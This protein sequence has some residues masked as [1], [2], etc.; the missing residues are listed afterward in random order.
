VLA[1]DV[2]DRPATLASVWER[3]VRGYAVDTLGLAPSTMDEQAGAAFLARLG[4]CDHEVTVHDGVGLGIDVVLTS[5]EVVANA[6][7]WEGAVVH[8]AAFPR[9]ETSRA[10]R[11]GRRPASTSR[12]ERPANRARAREARWF[13]QGDG[14][15]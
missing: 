13:H 4:A 10:P 9:V 2:F 8:L 14:D 12:I 7:T 15:R 6:L 3:L 1:L 5:D 11:G